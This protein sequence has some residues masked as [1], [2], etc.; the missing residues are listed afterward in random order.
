[1]AIFLFSHQLLVF[2]GFSNV[3]KFRAFEST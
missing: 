2:S 1:L 3:R